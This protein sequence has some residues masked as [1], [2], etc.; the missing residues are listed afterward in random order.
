MK[1]AKSKTINN[2]TIKEVKNKLGL[3]NRKIAELFGYKNEISYNN[4]PRKKH[5]ESAIIELYKI[6]R[7]KTF[8]YI[9]M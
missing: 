7:E 2:M 9:N 1:F 3:S 8:E 4:S 6:F 5:I